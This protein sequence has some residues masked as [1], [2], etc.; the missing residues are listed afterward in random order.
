MR[1]TLL[2]VQG[3]AR[4]IENGVGFGVLPRHIV[5]RVFKNKKLIIVSGGPK[6]LYNQLS[7]AKVKRRT[8]SPQAQALIDHLSDGLA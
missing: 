2:D 1:A 8:L 3:M 5:E 7:F 4:T 6:P